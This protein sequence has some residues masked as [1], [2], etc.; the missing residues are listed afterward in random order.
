MA[1]FLQRFGWSDDWAHDISS[2]RKV[3]DPGLVS[4]E[5]ILKLKE[6]FSFPHLL[7][8]LTRMKFKAS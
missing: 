5:A 6:L 3:S 8:F 2:V 1:E 4:K 7:L